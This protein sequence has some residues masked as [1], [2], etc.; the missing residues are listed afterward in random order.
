[1]AVDNVIPHANELI[2]FRR[3]VDS[4]ERVFQALSPTDAGALLMVRERPKR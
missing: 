4:D 2:E 1:M 3:L